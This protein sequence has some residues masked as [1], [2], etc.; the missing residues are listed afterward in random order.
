MGGETGD[1]DL[2]K[3][4]LLGTG[5]AVV[6]QLERLKRVEEPPGHLRVVGESQWWSDVFEP[7]H[8]R[9]VHSCDY[10]PPSDASITCVGLS[11]RRKTRTESHP[12][13]SPLSNIPSDK[14]FSVL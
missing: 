3:E 7:V 5:Y 4:P 6:E 2:H 12:W 11:G 13:G 10:R 9:M 14:G 1:V 8:P